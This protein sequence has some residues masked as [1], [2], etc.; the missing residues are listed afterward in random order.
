MGSA[1]CVLEPLPARGW[2]SRAWNI[3]TPSPPARAGLE[4]ASNISQPEPRGLMPNVAD[5]FDLK[6]DIQLE[7]RHHH[8]LGRR[9]R[10][11]DRRDR[12]RRTPRRALRIMA[13]GC[14][15][16]PK[17]IDLPAST[18][19]RARSIAPASGPRRASTSLAD[20]GRGRHGSSGIQSTQ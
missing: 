4:M 16:V 13:T 18:I 3:L 11:L 8:D 14:L 2:T 6:R 12:S 10:P 1:G 19:S 20:R 5:R 9:G 17:E 7:P 15:S